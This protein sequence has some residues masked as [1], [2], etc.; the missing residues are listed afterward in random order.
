MAEEIRKQVEEIR[1][2]AQENQELFIS[3]IQML[4]AAVDAKD[5][6]TQGHSARVTNYSVTIAK[7]MD[8]TDL[9]IE[10]VKIAA[11]LHDVGKIGIDDHI[12]RKPSLLTPEEY[13]EIKKHPEKGAN[14]MSPVKQ[15]EDIIPLMRYHHERVNGSGYPDGIQG[16]EIPVAAQI[17]SVADTFDAMTTD[18]PYQKA[19]EP[20]YVVAKIKSWVGIRFR[21]EVVDGFLRAFENGEIQKAET[22]FLVPNTP[23]PN[24]SVTNTPE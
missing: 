16:E 21:R 1:R 24:P 11:M 8:F 19:M 4:A 6:Y 12:L 15:L 7:N 18:R 23:V 13:E 14:I 5:P 22:A 20:E 9:E 17:L 10:K 3:S 2:A